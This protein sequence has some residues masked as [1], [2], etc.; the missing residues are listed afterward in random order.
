MTGQWAVEDMAGAPSGKRVLVQRAVKNE[1]NVIVAPFGPFSDVD[2]SMKFKPISGREDVSGGIVFQFAYGKYYVI[3]ANV[4]EDNFRFYYFD[5]S[6]GMLERASVRAPTLG[7]WH[8][9]RAVVAGDHV[10]GW[11]DG[12]LLLDYRDKRFSAGRVGLWSK[13]DSITAF[14]DIT[15]RGVPARR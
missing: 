14:D 10:Q 9:V 12:A 13:A 7:R 1:L 5:R 2:V 15:I 8:T 11:L 4:L 3:R 6:R